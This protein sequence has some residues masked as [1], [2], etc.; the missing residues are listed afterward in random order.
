MALGFLGGAL[1]GLGTAKKAGGGMK[2]SRNIFKR[3]DKKPQQQQGQSEE[4]QGGVDKSQNPQ[5]SFTSPMGADAAQNISKAS[6]EKQTEDLAGTAFRIRKSVVDINT[7]LKG[8]LTLDKLQAKK[9]RVKDKQLTK[10]KQ[11]RKLEKPKGEGKGIGR[12]VP[13]KAKSLLGRTIN[14]LVTIFWG[15][16]LMKFWDHLPKLMGVVKGIAGVMNWLKEWG[17]KFLNAMVTLVH[18]GDKLVTGLRDKVGDLFGE[19]G[20]KLFDKL[21]N[22]LKWVLNLAAIAAMTAGVVLLKSTSLAYWKGYRDGMLGKTVGGN[23][24]KYGWGR[25][26]KRALI[27]AF[28]KKGATSAMAWGTKA[29]ATGKSILAMK[30]TVAL[31]WVAAAMGVSAAIGEGLGWISKK[32]RHMNLVAKENYEK[33]KDK[34]WWDPRKWGSWG[35]WKLGELSNRIVGPIIS[36]FDIL[37]TPIRYLIAAIRYP[38]LDKQGQAKQRKN[39]AKFDG[40]IREQ[41]RRFVNMFDFMGIIS[42][43]TGSWGNI[44]GH[45]TA[46]KDLVR[47]LDADPYTSLM[48]STDPEDS[49]EIIVVEKT[50]SSSS[51]KKEETASG[52]TVQAMAGAFTETTDGKEFVGGNSAYDIL[53]KGA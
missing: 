39:L 37:G 43:E 52:D 22:T 15:W 40:R 24:L 8:S 23:I 17:G 25:A 42:D 9:K 36:L 53:H 38:F 20:L 28:G 21:G 12:F 45:E 31:G 32:G 46:Q 1:K 48:K 4:S 5:V 3:K 41:F 30:G 47:K 34:K 11:E 19:K 49:S 10:K 27:W 2:M 26:G 14:F 44:Y 51:S 33:Q 18:W 16:L 7:L 50:S 35:L 13:Q 29:I 6:D